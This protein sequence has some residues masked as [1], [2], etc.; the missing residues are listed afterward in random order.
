[1]VQHPHGKLRYLV[2]DPDPL[3]AERIVRR[4]FSYPDGDLAVRAWR[5]TDQQSID[6]WGLKPGEMKGPI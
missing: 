3:G 4:N 2:A 1:V 6:E 5:P